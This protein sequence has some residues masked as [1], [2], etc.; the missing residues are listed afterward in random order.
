MSKA[1]QLKKSSPEWQEIIGANKNWF[2]AETL[3][4]FGS[5][6]F[7][8]TLTNTGLGRVFITSEWNYTHEQK[9]FTIRLVSADNKIDNYGEFQGY[10]SLAET[11][12][13]IGKL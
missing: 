4:F 5:T 9:L 12:E 3:N 13:V 1:T 7:W 10:N 8:G 6:I 11:L 2:S